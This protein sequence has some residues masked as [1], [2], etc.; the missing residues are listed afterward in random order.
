MSAC[1]ER[2]S[3]LLLSIRC[4]RLIAHH[5]AFFSM[6]CHIFSHGLA[7]SSLMDENNG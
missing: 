6:V 3:L 5:L 2:G 4:G 7:H 1:L